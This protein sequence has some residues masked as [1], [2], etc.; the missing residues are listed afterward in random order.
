MEGKQ[1]EIWMRILPNLFFHS[2]PECQEKL[3]SGKTEIEGTEYLQKIFDM[4]TDKLRDI[5]SQKPDELSMLKALG[6]VEE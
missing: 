6:I 3:L 1:L 5:Y 2:T 4:D